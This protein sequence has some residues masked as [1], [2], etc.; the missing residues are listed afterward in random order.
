MGAATFGYKDRELSYGVM[1]ASI[2]RSRCGAGYT[3][4]SAVGVVSAV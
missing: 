1:V 4:L 2:S 3:R